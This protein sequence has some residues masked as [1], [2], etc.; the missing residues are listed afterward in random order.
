MNQY[1]R[2]YER[3]EKLIADECADLGKRADAIATLLQYPL[4]E[5]L[6]MD[7]RRM[8]MEFTDELA[9]VAS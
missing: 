4:A 1:L 8:Y 7:L 6:R 9:Q 3:S 2:A 5:N